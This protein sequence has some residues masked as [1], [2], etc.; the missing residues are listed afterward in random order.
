MT[1]FA[2]LSLLLVICIPGMAGNDPSIKGALRENIQ[3]AMLDHIKETKL[4]GAYVIYD[5]VDGE[6]VKMALEE[7]HSGIVKKGNFYVSCADFKSA[8][9]VK[10]DLDFMVAESQGRL[11][12]FQA[13]IH[14]VGN[15]K[16][17]YHLEEL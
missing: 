10:Y 6:L 9:G 17:A 8:D 1:R 2:A 3:D 7:L 4:D 16:R 12:V 13:L 11:K 14:K 15:D 5:S